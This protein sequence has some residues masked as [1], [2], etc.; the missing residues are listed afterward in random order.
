MN[1]FS[2]SISAYFQQY[3]QNTYT[4]P[5]LSFFADTVFPASSA[6]ITGS[7]QYYL[8]MNITDE[9]NV[10]SYKYSYFTYTDT[11]LAFLGFMAAMND[12]DIDAFI[13]ELSSPNY[14]ALGNI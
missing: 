14:V 11:V 10:N 7:S 8:I 2:T 12:E 5:P 13:K 3:E 1:R 9:F 6:Y 4:Q